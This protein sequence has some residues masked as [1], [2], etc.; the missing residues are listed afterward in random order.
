[1]EEQH[2]HNDILAVLDDH[3]QLS[4]VEIADV[5]GAHPVAVDRHC[6]QLQQDGYIHVFS[7]GIY[8]LADDGE[9]HLT[10][11]RSEARQ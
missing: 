11:H 1:M 4:V 3:E 10:Q 7:S 5:M 6:Y 8:Q 9:A 2:M